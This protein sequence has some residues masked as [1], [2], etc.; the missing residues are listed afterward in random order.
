MTATND[1]TGT[2]LDRNAKILL[3][4]ILQQGYI[5][6]EQRKQLEELLQ[7][8]SI[9]ICYADSAEVVNELSGLEKYETDDLRQDLRADCKS[10]L[11]AVKVVENSG[12]H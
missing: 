11:E 3:L 6:E 12:K 9:R 4:N 2:K 5:T 7:I 8:P 1:N 10:I